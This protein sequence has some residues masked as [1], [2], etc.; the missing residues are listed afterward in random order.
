MTSETLISRVCA[1]PIELS[2]EIM[3]FLPFSSILELSIK[4][5]RIA[6]ILL[7]NPTWRIVFSSPTRL[8]LLQKL[9]YLTLDIHALLYD[10]PF[11]HGQ[12]TKMVDSL[13][14]YRW[15]AIRN[16]ARRVDPIV[17]FLMRLEDRV[18]QAIGRLS[19][20][21]KQKVPIMLPKTSVKRPSWDDFYRHQWSLLIGQ[22]NEAIGAGID[23]FAK[24][25][26]LLQKAQET[27]SRQH[28]LNLQGLA[29]TLERCQEDVAGRVGDAA[30]ARVH[31]LPLI[32]YLTRQADQPKPLLQRDELSLGTITSY[33]SS[34]TYSEKLMY[35]IRVLQKH[36]P[37]DESEVVTWGKPFFPTLFGN[38]FSEGYRSGRVR[39]P[40][41]YPDPIVRAT[42]TLFRGLGIRLPLPNIAKR[43]YPPNWS[44]RPHV[45]NK[46]LPDP[47][48][49][50]SSEKE[51]TETEKYVREAENADK[52]A[53]EWFQAFLSCAAYFEEK[54]P[55]VERKGPGVLDSGS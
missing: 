39:K 37:L 7:S 49:G 23:H 26:G 1:L 52:K 21:Q 34:R 4:E 27:E 14:E 3:F 48:S 40:V 30:H 25:V 55:N 12:S 54:F 44:T 22:T 53:A 50:E 11:V 13:L 6:S 18:T 24:Y 47:I 32:S 51:E 5:D 19:V 8:E 45:V 41:Q 43:G 17:N 31:L 42:E 20:A 28:G 36:A 29:T 38:L 35:I 10:T 2:E 9:Y 33:R 16:W 46:I 15:Y